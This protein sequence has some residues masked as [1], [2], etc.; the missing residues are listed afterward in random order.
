M[1]KITNNG[2]INKLNRYFRMIKYITLISNFK[3]HY[4]DLLLKNF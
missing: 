3:N 2:V 1:A 4:T